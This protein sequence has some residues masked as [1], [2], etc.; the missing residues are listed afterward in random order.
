M[1]IVNIF[2]IVKG[3]LLSVQF[4]GMS[5][6]EFA[7]LFDNWN[8]VEYLEQ[9]FED[10]KA[11][12]QSGFY[13]KISVE[14]AVSRTIEEAEALEEYIR[15]V[16]KTGCSD[17]DEN[18]LDLTF[19]KLSEKDYSI[20]LLKSKAYGLHNHSW[21]RIYAIR[22]AENLYVVCGGGIKLTETMNERKH[23]LKELEKLEATKQY[24]KKI[25]LLN[26]DDYDFTEISDHE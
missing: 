6:D 14:E 8:D 1:K 19:H 22:I 18:R 9:F 15:N 11:D 3:S 5:S 16:A 20:L 10:N 12:L 4:D 21:L 26:E 13:G 2:A 17:P 24:L 23:L 7:L 25:D